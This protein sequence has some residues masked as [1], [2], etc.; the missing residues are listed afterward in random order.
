MTTPNETALR[1]LVHQHGWIDTNGTAAICPYDMILFATEFAPIL[2]ALAGGQYVSPGSGMVVVPAVADIAIQDAMLFSSAID[3]EG[4]MATLFEML[5]FS[6]E[7][8]SRSVV[9]AAYRYAMLA[10]HNAA[11]PV[12]PPVA[13]AA[14]E[15]QT[16]MKFYAA[17][18]LEELVSAQCRHIEKLQAKLPS[19]GDFRPQRVREG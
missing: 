10:A 19:T 12:Q 3:D 15:I 2:A 6:G 18:S 13:G 8:K 5:E 14:G 11:Q 9:A 16:L 17:S 4:P 1:E 7:N